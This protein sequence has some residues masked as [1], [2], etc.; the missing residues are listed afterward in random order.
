MK[1]RKTR[2]KFIFR[3]F[4]AKCFVLNPRIAPETWLFSTNEPTP[5]GIA[6]RKIPM[7][8]STIKKGCDNGT[9]KKDQARGATMYDATEQLV[10]DSEI[11]M[12]VLGA[13]GEFVL[14]SL[15]PDSEIEARDG[16]GDIQGLP[17]LRTGHGFNIH[18][19][20]RSARIRPRSGAPAEAK[21]DG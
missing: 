9:R 15:G 1:W 7:H 21:A 13:S 14:I 6:F 19:H 4:A 10:L 16:D 18:L 12:A 3:S 11:S 2:N 17:L 20:K 5:R 8:F